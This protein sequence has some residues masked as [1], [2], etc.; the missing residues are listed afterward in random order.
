MLILKSGRRW[1]ENPKTAICILAFFESAI[2][3]NS[4]ITPLVSIH[5]PLK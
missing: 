3:N 4:T 2:L 5:I 1:L